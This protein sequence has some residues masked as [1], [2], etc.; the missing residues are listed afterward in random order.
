MPINPKPRRAP[1]AGGFVECFEFLKYVL[2]LFCICMCFLK[3]SENVKIYLKVCKLSYICHNLTIIIIK[4][5][6]SHAVC[7]IQYIP[8]SKEKKIETFW[9]Y[10]EVSSLFIITRATH[11]SSINPINIIRAETR[12]RQNHRTI[13]KNPSKSGF[14]S[15]QWAIII[16]RCNLFHHFPLFLSFF[17]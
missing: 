6:L 12:R 9:D 15:L 16:S 3:P 4:R 7:K 5:Q 14:L 13:N 2:M 8:P 11:S 1:A 10:I 17:S